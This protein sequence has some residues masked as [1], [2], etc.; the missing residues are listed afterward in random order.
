MKKYLKKYIKNNLF[1][2]LWL[3][4]IFIYNLFG[5]IITLPYLIKTNSPMHYFMWIIGLV[6]VIL[7]IYLI[8]FKKWAFFG[9]AITTLFISAINSI[10]GEIIAVVIAMTWL[11]VL[12]RILRRRWKE[13]K[14]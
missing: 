8:R 6:E 14:W 11:T 3:A 5:L 7:I 2:F 4:I 13:L 1:L 9:L 10:N 12:Y